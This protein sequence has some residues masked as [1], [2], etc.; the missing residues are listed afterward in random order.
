MPTEFN[1]FCLSIGLI[2]QKGS[3]GSY[4]SFLEH[5]LS[6]FIRKITV[7]ISQYLFVGLLDQIWTLPRFESLS[8]PPHWKADISSPLSR[9]CS[10]QGLVWNCG[11]RLLTKQ[12]GAYCASGLSHG[13]E[14]CIS[15]WCPD[16]RWLQEPF[17]QN[18]RSLLQSVTLLLLIFVECLCG[19][20]TCVH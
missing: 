10:L 8:M 3:L 14:L 16:T 15:C 17:M 7:I 2:P 9:W 18:T 12:H 4:F 1:F 11:P 5:I 13:S 6:L 20:G 19:P